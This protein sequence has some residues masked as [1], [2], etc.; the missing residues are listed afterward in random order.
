[1]FLHLVISYMLGAS[2]YPILEILARGYSHVSM[3]VA[4][5]LSFVSIYLISTRLSAQ[6]L[7]VQALLCAL[8]ITAVEFLVGVVVN[9]WLGLGVWDYSRMPF[10]ILGQVCLPFTFLWF[11]LSFPALG[12][13]QL[14]SRI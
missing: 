13:S 14:I 10:S 12:L 6:P 5:G 9:L 2:V 7:W 3:S 11:F 8:A 4:G 1:M